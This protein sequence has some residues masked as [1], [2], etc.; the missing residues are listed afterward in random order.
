[1]P[2]A[3]SGATG[4]TATYSATTSV[5]RGD[6][7]GKDT[8]LKLLVAQMKY[9]DPGNP[10]DTNQLMAQTATFSQVEKLE[11]IAK[12]NASML[13]LQR[14]SSAGAMVGQTVTW[15]DSTG[16]PQTGVVTS[17]RL[18]TDKAEAEATIG[19]VAV[20][21]GRITHVGTR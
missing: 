6:Q 1:M 12:Q 8:F 13:A 18:A 3:V 11:E 7:M 15:T 14:S 17:V 16:A 20:P 9:Q 5:D 19:G 4:T 2:D 10:A 21:L